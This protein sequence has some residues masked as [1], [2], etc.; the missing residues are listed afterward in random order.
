MIVRGLAIGVGI[1]LGSAAAAAVDDPTPAAV[2]ERMIEAA[3]GEGAFQSLGV[4]EIAVHEEETTSEGNRE[5]GSYTAWA[6]TPQLDTLRMELSP[7][8]V[9]ASHKGVGWA[10]MDGEVDTRPQTP[11]MAVGTIH[12]KLFPLLLPFS[13]AMDGVHVDDK[14]ATTT[15]EGEDAW[16][17]TVSFGPMFFVGPV[18]N[19]DWL[20]TVRRSD[21]VLLAVEFLPPVEYRTAQ[22]EGVRYRYLQHADVEGVRLPTQVLLDGISF[23]GVETGHVRVTKITPSVRGSFDPELFVDPR[24]LEALEDGAPGVE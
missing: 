12:Q 7:R 14:V 18:M 8:V 13:L 6:Y 22:N 4:L 17:F 2:V 5:L 15:F 1:V 21:H 10:T 3:G 24:R 11:R 19:T 9:V 20:F 16:Q 23:D